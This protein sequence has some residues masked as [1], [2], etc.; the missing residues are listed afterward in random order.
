MLYNTYDP[1]F[2]VNGVFTC[3]YVA[4][5]H[6][7]SSLNFVVSTF[8]AL[9]YGFNVVPA[10]FSVLSWDRYSPSS[11]FI[12]SLTAVMNFVNAKSTFGII[13]LS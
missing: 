7:S 5:W 8:V 6:V 13:I 12:S 9:I 4:S 11:I 2:I 1:S 10:F 3:V